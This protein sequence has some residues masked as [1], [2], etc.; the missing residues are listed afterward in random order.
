[1][2]ILG[3]KA[4]NKEGLIWFSRVQFAMCQVIYQMFSAETHKVNVN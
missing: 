2:N 3:K 4:Y 1:M